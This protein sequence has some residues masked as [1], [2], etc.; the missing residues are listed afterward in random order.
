MKTS[1]NT[2]AYMGERG[3]DDRKNNNQSCLKSSSRY[4]I[5]GIEIENEISGENTGKIGF[6]VAINANANHG[7]GMSSAGS[8][9]ATRFFIERFLCINNIT[10]KMISELNPIILVAAAN[11]I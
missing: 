2:I 6:P 8:T 4:G 11:P 1:G 3:S 7:S 10:T 5:C 9:K